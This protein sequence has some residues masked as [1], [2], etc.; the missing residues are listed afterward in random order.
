M[1]VEN[2][3]GSATLSQDES[4]ISGETRS[5]IEEQQNATISVLCSEQ[6]ANLDKI[7]ELGKDVNTFLVEELEV[8]NLS[9]DLSALQHE[10]IQ[11][12]MD[13]ISNIDVAG[14][15]AQ[16][17][18]NSSEALQT[19]ELEKATSVGEVEEDLQHPR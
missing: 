3:D 19:K 1:S 12:G 6:T 13:H 18:A 11:N 8:D 10:V 17:A 7:V 14:M 2:D 4:T 16:F 5:T 15:F 9:Q